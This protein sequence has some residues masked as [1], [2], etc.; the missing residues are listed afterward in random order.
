MIDA[1]K[2]LENAGA[3][4]VVMSGSGSAVVG[5]FDKENEAR[6]VFERI[7]GFCKY[8]TKSI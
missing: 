8:L 7:D 5:I 4:D 2:T 6:E 3:K 1:R